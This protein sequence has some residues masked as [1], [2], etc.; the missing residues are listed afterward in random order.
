M[1]QQSFLPPEIK[2]RHDRC[3]KYNPESV[4]MKTY[5]QYTHHTP[6]TQQ[7]LDNYPV[8]ETISLRILTASSLLMFSKFTSF[9]WRADKRKINTCHWIN[10]C[11]SLLFHDLIQKCT[12][13]LKTWRLVQQSRNNAKRIDSALFEPTNSF[14]RR[15]FNSGR[16]RS[17]AHIKE[18]K[19]EGKGEAHESPRKD[20]INKKKKS[21]IFCRP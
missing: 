7:F 5:K 14:S 21:K 17:A 9:T 6:N 13:S 19:Q 15:V 12:S 10:R 8:L 3:S 1:K 16:S 4:N 11:A 20:V 2:H 18:W